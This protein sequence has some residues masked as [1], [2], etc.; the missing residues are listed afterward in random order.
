MGRE[1]RE[2]VHDPDARFRCVPGEDPMAVG[3]AA[4]SNDA[5]PRMNAP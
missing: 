2:G 3:V 5:A 1:R 4:H